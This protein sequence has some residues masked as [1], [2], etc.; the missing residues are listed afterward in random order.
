MYTEY[1]VVTSGILEE[2]KVFI[3][4]KGHSVLWNKFWEGRPKFH[5]DGF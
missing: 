3:G 4:M 1:L 2:E 5:R